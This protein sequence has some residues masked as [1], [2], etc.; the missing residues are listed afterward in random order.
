MSR[1]ATENRVD[2][3]RAAALILER[4]NSRMHARIRELELVVAKLEGRNEKALEQRLLELEEL[5]KQ[6]RD[7]LFGDSSEKTPTTPKPK[8]KKPKTGHGP[9]EQPNLPVEE[10]LHDLDEADRVCTTCGDKLLEWE[11]QFEESE[12]ID[13]IPRT[14]VIRRHKRKKY[15]CKCG[16]CVETAIGPVK[17]VEG[18]RYSTRFA[19]EVAA[20]K[21]LDH[22]PLE[23]Q[24]RK[25]SREG[26]SIDSQTLWDQ[27]SL[28]AYKLQP[29]KDRLHKYVLSTGL[30]GIDETYWKM[31][32]KYGGEA[33][34]KRWQAWTVVCQNAVS[35]VIL[36]SRSTEAAKE[37]L[38]DFR[39]I[40]MADGYGVYEHLD[41][42]EGLTF[43]ACWAHV[44][45]KFFELDGLVDDSIRK[46]ILEL[47]GFLYRVD[48]ETKDNPEARQKRRDTESR[49]IIDDIENW[50]HK[51]KTTT[52]PRSAFG[53][54]I[55]Y[56]LGLW[57]RLIRFLGDV[58]IPLDNNAS[59]RALRGL[60]IG[61]KNH[62]GS[63]SQRG[64][65]VAALFYSLC[66]SAKMV[67]IDPRA[68][69]EDA[70][71]RA[72][73]GE[74]MLLPHEMAAAPR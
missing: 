10:V 15:R 6:Q 31:L 33:A 57:P 4:D 28:V 68:Y 73:R 58:R 64:T 62:Y 52:L 37:V 74:E 46:E 63:K 54:A 25:F 67:G 59:E 60:V 18:G 14:I 16:E 40:A 23:R 66:E 70:L 34:Q 26:L 27:I 30:I 20:D 13:L 35:Y 45:R 36:P 61:R 19:V 41:S 29:L 1:L 56:A 7:R 48:Q 9:R 8:E 65:E 71:E 38:G 12:E 17:L 43:A 44:R 32:T 21:Y 3:L 39:G 11:G 51:H 2:V 24:A 5:L 72:L 49:R 47:I 69:L 42:K 53:K 22:M 50:L 55:A